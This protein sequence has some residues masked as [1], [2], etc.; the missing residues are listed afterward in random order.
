MDGRIF[1]SY[2]R[3]DAKGYAGRLSDSLEEHFG[4]NRV[5]R[6]IEDI[7]G[8][9]AF[10]EVIE[11]NIQSADAVIILIG[12]SWLSVTGEGNVPRLQ[13]EGDWVA[14]EIASAIELGIPLF[15]VLIEQTPMPRQAELPERLHPILKYNAI[16]LSDNSWSSDVQRLAKFLA[17]DIPSVNERKI[18][19]VKKIASL[20]IF[21]TLAFTTFFLFLNYLSFVD[22]LKDYNKVV[23][24]W[25]HGETYGSQV[26]KRIGE[27]SSED[28]VVVYQ[29]VAYKELAE[30]NVPDSLTREVEKIPGKEEDKVAATYSLISPGTDA[31]TAD[32][33]ALL[34]AYQIKV[35]TTDFIDSL[36]NQEES[37]LGNLFNTNTKEYIRADQVEL[38]QNFQLL[39]LWQSGIPY[40]GIVLGGI[41]I[42]YIMPLIDLE[43]QIY[44]YASI[45]TGAIG[46][47][48][49]VLF[50]VVIDG[51]NL[52]A[53]WTYFGSII[54]ATAMLTFMNM[55]GFKMK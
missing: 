46:S 39:E 29:D 17:F 4:N 3:S 55:S 45:G 49:I 12:P 54:I 24:E 35:Y 27:L 42:L 8:G 14:Q 47:F 9:A 31:F 6:D 15:P 21:G 16:T 1:I 34:D 11:A 33:I 38:V 44:L 48:V 2:R 32:E 53:M 18:N 50:Y 23:E 26:I 25:K 28:D 43:R 19:Y 5:F 41:L 20:S 10:G 36:K 37:F 51:D 22:S 52:E 40:I 30:E 7:K 13:E